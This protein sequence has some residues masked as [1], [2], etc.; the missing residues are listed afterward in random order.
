MVKRAWHLET[1]TATARM[2]QTKEGPR[3]QAYLG[4]NSVRE[5][6]WGGVAQTALG[7]TIALTESDPPSPPASAGLP[8]PHRSTVTC[9]GL[10]DEEGGGDLRG[11][12]CQMFKDA[13]TPRLT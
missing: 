5:A 11:W 13:R 6:C 9:W 1:S 7:R 3:R 8:T 2:I 10:G 4:R 12:G